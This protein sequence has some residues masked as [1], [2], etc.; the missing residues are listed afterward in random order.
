MELQRKQS[1]QEDEQMCD[2][3]EPIIHKILF[4][5][6][7]KDA[8]RTSVLSKTWQ[9][10]WT[11][12]P[13]ISFEELDFNAGDIEQPNYYPKT[14]KA[15]KMKK[16]SFM[17]YI[18]KTLQSFLEHNSNMEEFTLKLT[19]HDKE[20]VLPRVVKW[21][22]FATERKV[23]VL[24]LCLSIIDF[25]DEHK[26]LGKQAYYSLPQV[27]LEA[28]TISELQLSHC[29]LEP[30]NEFKFCHLK[31]LNLNDV[32]ID[33]QVILNLTLSCPLIEDFRLNNC[34]GFEHL[35]VSSL[36]RLNL[37]HIV[38]NTKVLRIEIDE[39]SLQTFHY[40]SRYSY[41]LENEHCD[42]YLEACKNLKRL[43]FHNIMAVDL[44]ENISSK[45][46]TLEVLE[47]SEWKMTDIEISCQTLRVL[48]LENCRDL[49]MVEV[50]TPNLVSLHCRMNKLPFYSF[51]APSLQE[52]ELKFYLRSCSNLW[53]VE[54]KKLVGK[55]NNSEGLNL[56]IHSKCNGILLDGLNERV[57]SWLIDLTELRPTIAISSMSLSN[58]V[59]R[60]L[61]DSHV[62]TLSILSSSSKLLE[63]LNEKLINRLFKSRCL[64]DSLSGV[65]VVNLDREEDLEFSEW[66]ALSKS[67]ETMD[68]K[69]TSFKL[70]WM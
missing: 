43:Y 70:E 30:C 20:F 40:W 19:Y 23:K 3:P 34:Q 68:Y 2:L 15:I 1:K 11:S 60:F 55:F 16:E 28:K 39:P 54:L 56:V 26:L 31:A 21:L 9:R 62:E 69:I 22:T 53:F 7:T 5:L 29:K 47:I 25:I 36:P 38:A 24:S 57:L 51:D 45:F 32:H 50:D 67:L 66:I 33:E 59:E 44:L 10:A 4:L 64:H 13:R 6:N 12:F 37:F 18:D 58:L 35:M 65:K 61:L 8:A 14:N 49:E 27:V 48:T 46:P 52:V 41:G 63:V 42:I 17:A